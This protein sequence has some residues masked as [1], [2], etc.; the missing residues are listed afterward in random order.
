MKDLC[1]FAIYIF[2]DIGKNLLSKFYLSIV[3]VTYLSIFL[4]DHFK[5]INGTTMSNFEAHL[6]EILW[7]NWPRGGNPVGNLIS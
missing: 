4:Q 6:T 1:G 7:R 2:S 3:T 5:R